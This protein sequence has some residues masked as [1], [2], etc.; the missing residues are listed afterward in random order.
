MPLNATNTFNTIASG[1][2]NFNTEVGSLTPSTPIELFE[3]DMKDVYP[4]TAFITTE[5]QP[6]SNGV[7]RIFN[8]VNLFNL[9]TNTRGKLYWQ[10]NYYYPFPISVDGFELN[11]VGTMANPKMVLANT[12]P[13]GSDNSF[14]KY[15]RLQIQSFG[16]LAGC[17]FTRI[18]T[19]LKYLD[20]SNFSNNFNPY[21]KDNN[22]FE[23]ELPKDIYYIERKEYESKTT[24]EYSLSSLLDIENVALPGRKIL[25]QKCPF[26]YRG[27]GCLYEYHKRMTYAH[28]GVYAGCSNVPANYIT[29]P[30]EAP[31]TATDNDELYLGKIFTGDNVNGISD[32]YIFTG[33]NHIRIAT[34]VGDSTWSFSNFNLTS[35]SSISSQRSLS[36]NN[37]SVTGA[38][39]NANGLA[40]ITFQLNNPAEITKLS[41]NSATTITNNFNFY[42]SKDNGSTWEAVKT[43]LGVAQDWTLNGKA[44]GSYVTGWPTV[45][46]HKYWKLSTTNTAAGTNL[47]EVQLSGQYRIA[48]SGLWGLG[49]TYRRGEFTFL[50]KMGIK[51]YYVSLTGH[52]SNPFNAPPNRIFWSTDSCSKEISA[53]RNRWQLNPYFKPVIWPL[54]RGGWSRAKMYNHFYYYNFSP[55]TLDSATNDAGSWPRR[56]MVW[57]PFGKYA[58]G[59]PK[60]YTGDYLNGFLP[61]G[62]FPGV[63]KRS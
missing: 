27:E 25:A 30:L 5:N 44:A 53:C 61:F 47:T 57:D 2:K 48:D 3:I 6:I 46:M 19:F 63:D 59:L 43:P 58:W 51:Y 52:L 37:F 14:Y 38:N 45:G 28:S 24:I 60:D 50:E 62:G 41:L 40:S 22:F 56:P 7:L 16:D 20:P 9:A 21:A 4:Q 1:I 13:D 18:R 42:F 32:A 29:L 49:N 34:G 31:P 55:S 36:D 17:K 54:S 10:G 33:I 11:S 15:A 26:Q 39:T 35:G 23:L 12:S 8:D